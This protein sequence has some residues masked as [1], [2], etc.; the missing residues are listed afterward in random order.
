[1]KLIL[2]L[3]NPIERAYSHWNMQRDRGYDTLSFHEAI[4]AE[5]KRRLKSLPWQNRR[6]SYLDRGYFSEQIRRLRSF[7]PKE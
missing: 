5:E 3:R 2:I 6:Y 1:M 4:H 7:F